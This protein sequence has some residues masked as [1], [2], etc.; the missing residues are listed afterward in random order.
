M[1]TT[2]LVSVQRQTRTESGNPGQD[3]ARHPPA[4]KG[5]NAFV[6]FTQ[7]S[8]AYT[9]LKAFLCC[10]KLK[11]REKEPHTPSITW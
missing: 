11:L 6:S 4:D 3:Q 10:M 8:G 9:W 7:F 1:A 2:H 5:L